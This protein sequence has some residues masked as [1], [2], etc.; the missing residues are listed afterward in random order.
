MLTEA[1]GRKI[2][3]QVLAASR[4]DDVTVTLEASNAAH[5][6][7]ARNTPSTSGQQSDHVLSVQSTFGKKSASATVNQLDP[8]TLAQLVQRSEQLARLGPDDPERMPGLGPQAYPAVAAY[9]E[10]LLPRGAAD[11][12]RGTA[13]CIEQARAAGL[14]AA[15]YSEATARASWVGSRRGLSGYHRTTEASFSQTVRTADAGGSGWSAG[16]GNAVSAIDYQRC[17]SVSIAKALASVQPRPLAPGKYVTI[18]E[19][20]CVASLVQML[21]FSMNQRSAEEGRSFFSEPGGQSKLGRQLFP[22]SITIRSDPGSSLAPGTPWG[23]EELPQLPRTWVERGRLTSLYCERFWADK[24]QREPVP[25]PSNVLMSGGQGLLDE[26]IAD[27]K[28]GVLITSLFYI[29][30]VDPRT[31]LLTGLT[32]DGVFWIEK[33]KLSHPVTNFRWNESPAR[34]LGNVDAMTAAV[35]A[36]PRESMAT[37][38][39]VPALRV[40]EFELSSV[41]DAV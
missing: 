7:Y 6:R 39:S 26:L 19:P 8:S 33:G 37:T 15:G 36:A 23:R 31:L 16:V 10:G 13:L 40:K 32:R 20:S 25:P 21:M 27:T 1:E 5:L 17:S 9:D 41:S 3:E 22:E 24:R 30:F 35:R 12:V 4:A 11:M 2:I 34:V 29:R 28:Q 14:S 18:L 38:V